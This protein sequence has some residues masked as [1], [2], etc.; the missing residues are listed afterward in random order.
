M[1]TP[2]GQ[3]ENSPGEV[4]TKK[5]ATAAVL[6]RCSENCHFVAAL[7]ASVGPGDRNQGTQESVRVILMFADGKMSRAALAHRH[8]QHVGQNGEK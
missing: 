7:I 4:Q 2:A 3:S 5:G 1:W 8:S 6:A